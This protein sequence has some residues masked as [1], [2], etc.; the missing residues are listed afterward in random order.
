[1]Y[2]QGG[3]NDETADEGE[4]KDR[5]HDD[6]SGPAVL[7]GLVVGKSVHNRGSDSNKAGK[8]KT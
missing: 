2:L 3:D 8:L 6:N 5:V 1:M 7:G 4:A